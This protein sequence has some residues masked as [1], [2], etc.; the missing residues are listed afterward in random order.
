MGSLL[1][2]CFL[3]RHSVGPKTRCS[4]T[5][6]AVNTKEAALLSIE[7]ESPSCKRELLSALQSVQRRANVVFLFCCCRIDVGVDDEEH[8]A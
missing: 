8:E 3:F 2:D 1:Q 6:T 4:S 5:T 7:R